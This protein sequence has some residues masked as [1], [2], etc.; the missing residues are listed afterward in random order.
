[1]TRSIILEK[2]HIYRV[3]SLVFYF[4]FPGS[5][6]YL[7]IFS[8]CPPLFCSLPGFVYSDYIGL[9][10]FVSFDFYAFYRFLLPFDMLFYLRAS[11][12]AP[13]SKAHYTTRMSRDAHTKF[14]HQGNMLTVEM[15]FLQQSYKVVSDGNLQ[16][17]KTP[18]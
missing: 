1:M 15:D 6:F 3:L 2:I 10:L 11:S 7:L 8:L 12:S 18:L 16:T 4:L 17:K 9:L 13:F 14:W 5:F